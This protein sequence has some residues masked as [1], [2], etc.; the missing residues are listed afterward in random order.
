MKQRE[1][2]HVYEARKQS[3]DRTWRFFQHHHHHIT[4]HLSAAAPRRRAWRM[5]KRRIS[6]LSFAVDPLK[7]KGACA[8]ILFGFKCLRRRIEYGTCGCIQRVSNTNGVH[9]HSRMEVVCPETACGLSANGHNDSLQN[10][11][12]HVWCEYLQDWSLCVRKQPSARILH[13]H[14]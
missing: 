5:L 14:T 11:P 2:T 4:H 12:S 13:M 7:G 10:L 1:L 6:W 9:V 3:T 8:S